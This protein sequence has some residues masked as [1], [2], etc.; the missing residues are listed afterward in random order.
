MQTK[1]RAKSC[2]FANIKIGKSVPRSDMTE[3][4]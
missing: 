3:A 4:T 2:F 1:L